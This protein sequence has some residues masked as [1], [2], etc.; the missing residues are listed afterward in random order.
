MTDQTQPVQ[1]I[2]ASQTAYSSAYVRGYR[3]HG[4]SSTSLAQLLDLPR[5][6]PPRGMVTTG[7]ILT[8]LGVP[9]AALFVLVSLWA[10]HNETDPAP[11]WASV[12][13]PLFMTMPVWLPGLVCLV[14]G[15]ARLRGFRRGAP[16]REMAW[17]VWSTARYCARDHVVFLP[18]GVHAPAEFARSLIFDTAQRALAG[19]HTTGLRA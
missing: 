14:V 11:A 15:Y 10:R 4:T 8:L 7:W 1:G 9:L 13:A 19:P 2:V 17:Q 16:L 12:M 5:P 18:H 3:A 6:R